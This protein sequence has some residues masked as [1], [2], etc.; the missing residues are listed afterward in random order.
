[1]D[2]SSAPLS[3][4]TDDITDDT[5][6]SQQNIAST[7]PN[8]VENY[9]F[10]SVDDLLDESKYNKSKQIYTSNQNP[11]KILKKSDVSDKICTTKKI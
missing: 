2:D 8:E 11:N 5:K 4:D 7:T 6:E 9:M 3:V 1:M 10:N